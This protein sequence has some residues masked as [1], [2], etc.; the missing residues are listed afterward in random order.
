MTHPFVGKRVDN[1][2]R[3]IGRVIINNKYIELKICLL[4]E[5]RAY[6]ITNGRYTVEHRD[7][8][9]S[10][11]R[12]FACREVDTAVFIWWEPSSYAMQMVGTYLLHFNL[13]IALRR[14][15]I[16]E[17]FLATLTCIGL[18]LDIQ[19]ARQVLY[20]AQTTESKA[21]LIESGILATRKRLQSIILKRRGT[22]NNQRTKLK[23]VPQTTRLIIY[24]RS[25][26]QRTIDYFAIVAIEHSTILLHFIAHKRQDIGRGKLGKFFQHKNGER[27]Q[28]TLGCIDKQSTI[29]KRIGYYRNNF[30]GQ[31]IYRDF[32]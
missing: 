3:P 29:G 31:T 8:H 30:F 9:R 16:I 5:H 20:A 24:C 6:C 23:I 21:Q 15:H 22:H 12:K 4:S 18:D 27:R 13:H 11:N 1:L 14:I 10:L 2:A 32:L 25:I 17:L 7:N 19:I 26:A 28:G